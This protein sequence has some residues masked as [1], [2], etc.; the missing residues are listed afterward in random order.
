MPLCRGLVVLRGHQVVTVSTPAGHA[1]LTKG[2]PEK[3]VEKVDAQGKT[4]KWRWE[5]PEETAL[6]ETRE[7]SGI[8]PSDLQILTGHELLEYNDRGNPSVS[9][10]VARYV[11]E[12]EPIFHCEPDEQA[13][14]GFQDLE[15]VA[16]DDSFLPQRQDLI[17]KAAELLA[18]AVDDDFVSGDQWVV[19][20]HQNPVLHEFYGLDPVVA[21]FG[22]K[23]SEILRHHPEKY[24]LAIHPD[25]TVSV[26]ELLA[27]PYWL[28]YLKRA[29]TLEDLQQVIKSDKKSRF[30]FTDNDRRVRAQQGFSF[31]VDRDLVYER[32]HEPLEVCIHGTYKRYLDSIQAEGLKVMDREDIHCATGLPGT[33]KSGMRPECEVAIYLNTELMLTDEIPIYRSGNGVLLTPGKKGVLKPCYFEKVVLLR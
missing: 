7:E 22:R 3:I 4:T 33:V 25:A 6:R 30:A 24:G 32:I 5:A 12:N 9:Y 26:D 18:A 29:P 13:R 11:G 23:L 1:G 20:P 28:T 17:A 15:A 27:A 31:P 19:T 14:V 2:K 16:E 10:T 21:K 8:A